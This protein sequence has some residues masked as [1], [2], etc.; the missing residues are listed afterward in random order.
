MCTGNETKAIG[1]KCRHEYEG[2]SNKGDDRGHNTRRHGPK[3]IEKHTVAVTV[4]V[5]RTERGHRSTQTGTTTG[6]ETIS[7]L[8][9]PSGLAIT[10]R[11]TSGTIWSNPTDEFQGH[12]VLFS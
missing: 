9:W 8:R 12:G 7:H 5:R 10:T 2:G 6:A 11:R 4:N 3:G 1:D